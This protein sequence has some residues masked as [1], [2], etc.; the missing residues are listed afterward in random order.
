MY[1]LFLGIGLYQDLN[2]DIPDKSK[3]I[4]CIAS[5]Q[6]DD[7]GYA[8]E[9]SMTVGATPSTAA[10]V[11]LQY[12]LNT[13][14]D[15]ASLDWLVDRIHP[16]GGFTAIPSLPIADLL[17]TATALHALNLAGKSLSDEQTEICLDFIDTL[18]SAKGAFCASGADQAHD[19]EYTYY[20]LMAI[21]NLIKTAPQS[22]A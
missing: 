19:T 9:P 17:S 20:G 3:M 8:N 1:G 21:G 10:A 4:D 12:F 16:A 6:R 15:P 18:W 7:R 5:L 22:L 13:E 14:I 11:T 2:V